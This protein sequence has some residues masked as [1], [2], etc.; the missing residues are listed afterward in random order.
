[1]IDQLLVGV[2]VNAFS[3][4]IFGKLKKIT[5]KKSILKKV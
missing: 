2:S 3:E 4:L 5:D 1:M